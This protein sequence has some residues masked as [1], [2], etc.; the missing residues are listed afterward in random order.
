MFEI[1][2]L[3]TGGGV[4]SKRRG[5][6]AYLFKYM[7]LSILLDC[8][9]GTQERISKY[10]LGVSSIDIIGISHLHADHVLGLPGLIQTMSMLGRTKPLY[11]MGPKKLGEFIEVINESTKFTPNF[12]IIFTEEFRNENIEIKKFPTCHVI[13]SYGFLIIE[14]DR[15]KVDAEKLRSEGIKD[16]RI[17]RSI[18]EGKE[19]KIGERV[20]RPDDY[21]IKVNGIKIGYTGDTRY[22]EKVIKEVKGV[23][24]LLHDST[25][26]SSVKDAEE[27]GHSTSEHAAEVALRAEVKRLGL[28]HISARYT[29]TYEL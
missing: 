26:S 17:I 14:K 23:D 8:G 4:P 3:G 21:L 20:L 19:V 5:L 7:N 24:L 9:E 13:E 11:I 29:D 22:C 28:I 6:P 16:W 1:Y 15:Y 12:K 27:Y 18:K 10:G 25:F 2:F